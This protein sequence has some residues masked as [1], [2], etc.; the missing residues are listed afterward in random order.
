M[1]TVIV[2]AAADG[3]GR[4]TATGFYALGY[5]V[6]GVDVNEPGLAELAASSSAVEPIVA[7]VTDPQAVQS[8]VSEAV[9]ATGQID[10]LVNVVGGSRP[11]KSTIDLP[12]EE[13]NQLLAVN[14]T[15]VFLMCQAVSPYLEAAGSGVIVNVSSGSRAFAVCARTRATSQPRPESPRSPGR[16]PSTMARKGYAST[17]SHPARFAPR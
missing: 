10:A 15:S 5:R 6:I 17:V 2:T 13:W 14:L 11:G 16:S 7:D 8:V 4:A 3:I 12:L 1:R 9:G